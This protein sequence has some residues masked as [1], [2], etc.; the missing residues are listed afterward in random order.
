MTETQAARRL[1]PL[2]QRLVD[3]RLDGIDRA[4]RQAGSGRAERGQIVDEVERQLWE[5]LPDSAAA[6]TRRDVLAALAKLDPPEAY[7]PDDPAPKSRSEREAPAPAEASAVVAPPTSA[8]AVVSCVL[9]GL[10]L[11]VVA[12]G[13]LAFPPAF[14]AAVPMLLAALVCAIVAGV[15]ISRGRQ[16]GAAWVATGLAF[17]ATL[18]LES[19]SWGAAMLIGSDGIEFFALSNPVKALLLAGLAIWPLKAWLQGCPAAKA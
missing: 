9:S 18:L 4:L 6:P 19:L 1:S 16:S 15:Q 17:S 2:L 5:M 7:L 12:I 14:V 10:G 3:E 11:L 13:T 8:L